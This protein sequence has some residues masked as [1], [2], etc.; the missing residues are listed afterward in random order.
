MDPN[1]PKT[2]LLTDVPHIINV[3]RA[4]NPQWR[5]AGCLR[6]SG[7][8]P[9]VP[10]DPLTRRRYLASMLGS[11]GNLG[12]IS[13]PSCAILGQHGALLGHHWVILAILRPSWG[14][15]GPA[16]GHLG[17]SWSHVG[18]I[19]GSFWGHLGPLMCAKMV[20]EEAHAR[21]RQATYSFLRPNT[22]I[23]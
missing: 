9:H 5:R 23:K 15:L 20:Q 16:Q 22:A 12:G 10:T 21:P 11:R 3:L 7:P 6:T 14:H 19:L 2:Q 8:G 1:D 18:A 13:E 4:R 17:L